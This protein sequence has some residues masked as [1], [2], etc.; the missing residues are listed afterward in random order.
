M[1]PRRA[2]A[3]KPPRKPHAHYFEPSGWC[4]CGY[5]DDGL[6]YKRHQLIQTTPKETPE[7]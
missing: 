7:T 3:P 1:P 4:A 6:L 5:R 2:Q